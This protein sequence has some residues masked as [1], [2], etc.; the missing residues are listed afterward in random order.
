MS[1]NSNLQ[2]ADTVADS[3]NLQTDATGQ[4]N[5]VPVAALI[6]ERKKRQEIETRLAEIEAK[7]Q[8]TLKK[9]LEEQGKFKELLSE[10]EKELEA[11]KTKASAWDEYQTSRREA[12]LSK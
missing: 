1:E 7:N 4:T 10:R 8:E 2:N 9:E 12:L 6:A 11:A 5:S 3:V